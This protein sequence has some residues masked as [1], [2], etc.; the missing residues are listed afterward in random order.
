MQEL[1]GLSSYDTVEAFVSRALLPFFEQIDVEWYIR[2]T[3]SLDAQDPFRRVADS[4][5]ERM[6]KEKEIPVKSFDHRKAIRVPFKAGSALT[7]KHLVE[8]LPTLDLTRDPDSPPATN[9]P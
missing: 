5:T 6:K 9:E 2:Q 7:K 8:P 4:L 1:W 3:S